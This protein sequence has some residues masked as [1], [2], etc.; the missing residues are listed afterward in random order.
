MAQ[1]AAAPAADADLD[2]ISDYL[3]REGGVS[4]AAKYQLS[5]EALF[6]RLAAHPDSGAP[7]PR[8]GRGVRIA[9]V[10]PYIVAYRHD[11]S[12]DEVIVLRVMHGAR[13]MS[14]RALR[15]V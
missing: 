5:F 1:V 4:A 3:T 7:R 8:Y 6:E 2:E 10:R 9:V 15:G 11:P 13:R 14:A 12:L